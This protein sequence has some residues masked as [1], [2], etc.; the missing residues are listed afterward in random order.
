[1]SALQPVLSAATGFR[2]PSFS[3]VKRRTTDTLTHVRRQTQ[4]AYA[5]NLCAATLCAL[6]TPQYLCPGPQITWRSARS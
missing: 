3:L 1:M 5:Y 2:L 6:L 4:P